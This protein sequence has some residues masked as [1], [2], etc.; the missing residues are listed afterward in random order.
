M[1]VYNC[2]KTLGTALW[3]ILEQTY[4]DRELLLVDGGSTCHR[5]EVG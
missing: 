2:G 5:P 4:Q 3:S 1:P